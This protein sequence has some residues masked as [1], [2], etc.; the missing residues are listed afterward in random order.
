M[1]RY[2]KKQLWGLYK[3]L[4]EE[5]KKSIFSEKTAANIYNAC[6]E[7]DL[8][9]DEKISQ[10]AENVGY[11][12]MGLVPPEEFKKILSKEIKLKKEAIEIIY[13]N[14]NDLVFFPIKENLEKIYNIKIELKSSS[15]D[16]S[17][18]KNIEEKL[19]KEDIYREP[20]E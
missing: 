3:E 11:V 1:P 12:L 14:I 7:A 10:V 13:R 8:K 18:L 4:P 20:I 5:L 6:K 17:R 16:V 15:R 2:S 9:K 19:R